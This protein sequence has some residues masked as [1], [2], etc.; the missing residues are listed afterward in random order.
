MNLLEVINLNKQYGSIETQRAVSFDV[1]RGGHL[2]LTWTLRWWERNLL[3]Y[4]LATYNIVS[5]IIINNL[6]RHEQPIHFRQ[7]RLGCSIHRP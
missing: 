2:W 4:I 5:Y 3:T 7:N 6:K 1:E